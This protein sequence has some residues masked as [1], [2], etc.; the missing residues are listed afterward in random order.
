MTVYDQNQGDFYDVYCRL[1]KQELKGFPST[2][3]L[4]FRTRLSLVFF[5]PLT[6][7]GAT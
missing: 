1:C 3:R 7:T 5:G 4:L 2:N 6:I